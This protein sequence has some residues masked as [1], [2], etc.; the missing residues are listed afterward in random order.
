MLNVCM[1]NRTEIRGLRFG[2]PPLGGSR[3][4]PPKGGTP[5]AGFRNAL[6]KILFC[7]AALGFVSIRLWAAPLD[8]SHAKIVVLDP[9]QIPATKAAAMLRDEVEKRTRISLAIVPSLPTGDE[10]VI[11]IGTAPEFTARSYRPPAGGEVPAKPDAYSLWIDTSSRKGPTV[12]AA[13]QDARGTV[14][15]VGRLLRLFEMGRDKLQLDDAT[16]LASAPRYSLRGHQ[17]GFRP[18]TNAYD[19]WTLAMW[20]QYYR[21][22]MVFGMNAVELIPP[23]SD[24]DADSPHFPRPPME[25]MIDMSRLADE[26]GLDVWI[27]Y[28]SMDKD[29]SDPKTVEFA[30]KEREEVFNKL[31]RIDAVFVPGGDPGDV[32]PDILLDLCEKAKQVLNRYHPRAQLWISPQ[33][34]DRPNV[35]H[36]K[37]WLKMFL[38]LLKEKQ[39]PWLDGVVF[40]PQVETTLAKLRQEV[41][42][43][44]ALR[45]Y[46]DITHSKSCQYPVPNWDRAYSETE[47]RECINPR[48]VFYS[49]LFRDLQQYS[50]GFLTYSEGC[51]DDFNKVLWSCLG[52]DPDMREAEIAREYSRYFIGARDGDEFARG[53]MA[54]EQDWVGRLQTNTAVDQ[55]LLLFQA[56]EKQATPQEKLNWRFQEGLYRAYYD[57]YLRA[58]LIYETK[59]EEEAIA[60]LKT[61]PQIGALAAVDQAEKI[62]NKAVTERVAAD[63][64]SRV[65]ELAEAL[66]Q[67][68]R[69]QLSVPRYRA[70]HVSRGANL[71]DIDKPLNHSLNLKNRFDEIRKLQ[72]EPERL[73]GITSLLQQ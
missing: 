58:R 8:L 68:I 18:K 50:V 29:Y 1:K 11:L 51:N 37:G 16:H 56:L 12:C 69:M 65:Y 41:P 59:L 46:P 26:Y 5:N 33:G 3:A 32:R 21:D 52:W 44:Y 31:T 38:D 49:K 20:E 6:K 62:L 4:E 67:S 7:G 25:M 28:P 39:P 30:L 2:V 36:R 19:A 60:V 73:E 72:T 48:P 71:D 63:L 14:F 24:D 15:A 9:R 27:W 23:R 43:Q 61:A 13:G 40:G 54:L 35:S 53:L 57:G 34:F 64:R 17:L 22:M 10:A 42:P 47:G 66:F 45:Q 55:T 70:I